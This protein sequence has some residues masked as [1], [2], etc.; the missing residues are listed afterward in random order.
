MRCAIATIGWVVASTLLCR[1]D[2]RSQM[3]GLPAVPH[4]S[5]VEQAEALRIAHHP[6]EAAQLLGDWLSSHEEDVPALVELAH[7]RIDS[8]EVP[9]AKSVLTKALSVSPSSE[10]ANVMLG[11]LL[12]EERAYPEAMDRFEN[13]LAIDLRSQDAR[14]GEVAAVFALAARARAE[15][16]PDMALMAL[17]HAAEKLPDDAPLLYEDGMQAAAL[18]RLPEARS[19]LQRVCQ[20]APADANALY[21]LARVELLQSDLAAAERDMRAYLVLQPV[22]ASAH[23]GLGRVLEVAQKTDEARSEFARSIELQPKQTESYYELGQMD[24]NSS[25]DSEAEAEFRK[26]ME[27]DPTHGGALAGLGTLMFRRKNYA[28]AEQW[29]TKAEKT[30]PEYQ[31]AHYYR[32]LALARMGRKQ[33]SDEEMQLAMKLDKQQLGA[34]GGQNVQ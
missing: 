25:R 30:A 26:V 27:R 31:P 7:V 3:T 18:G 19:A 28:E 9:E 12:L 34:P 24:L 14:Q 32:A 13:V 33:E 8:G 23:Y 21:G 29:L 11:Q 4:G 16:H 17:Q 5:V 10:S 22:D 1:G 2:A 15:G 6:N 20:L